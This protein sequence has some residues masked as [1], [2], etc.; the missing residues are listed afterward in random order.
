MDRISTAQ[1]L[2]TLALK[3]VAQLYLSRPLLWRRRKFDLRVVALLV[4]AHPLELYVHDCYWPR[5]AER[6]HQTEP[7]EASPTAQEQE[8]QRRG[9]VVS[10]SLL[11]DPRVSLTAMHLLQSGGAVEGAGGGGGSAC[12]PHYEVRFFQPFCCRCFCYWLY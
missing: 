7:Q 9:D 12:H 8:Q 11:E 4:S 6:P 5:V 10:L 3:Q 1:A 2:T